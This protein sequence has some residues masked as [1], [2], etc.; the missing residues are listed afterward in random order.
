RYERPPFEAEVIGCD[1]CHGP[2]EAHLR[3]PLSRN[4]IN[5]KKLSPRA[6]SSVCEQ[7]HLAGE[8]RIP[9]PAR[10]LA[11]FRPG[12]ELEE[13]FSV[14]VR[15]LPPDLSA[16]GALKVVSHVEQLALSTCARKSDRMWCGSCHDSHDKPDSPRQYYR[17]RCLA[18]HGESLVESHSKPADNCIGC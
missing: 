8:A 12:Q 9:N 1:R 6:R 3:Q 5:P 15:E 14:Y 18:C 7:C 4:I 13:V 16:A 11:D 2:V 10:S 17:A